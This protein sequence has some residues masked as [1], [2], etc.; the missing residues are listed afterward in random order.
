[1]KKF[2]KAIAALM[3]MTAAIVAVGCKPENE[4]NNGNG[5]NGGGDNGG[6][7]EPPVTVTFTVSGNYNSHNY[8]DLGLPSG[9]LWATCN[10]GADS[11]EGYGYYLAWGETQPKDTTYYWDTY[12][13]SATNDFHGLTK[14]CCNS[15]FGFNGFTDGLK[16][17]LPEDDAATVN[18]GGDWQTPSRSDWEE[19]INNCTNEWITTENANGRLFTAPNGNTLFLPAAGIYGD[20]IGGFESHAHYWM[21]ELT[22]EGVTV[23]QDY[24]FFS[25]QASLIGSYRCQGE[26][27]RPVL[28]K[29][30]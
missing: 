27:V 18:W 22:E 21:N 13:Y 30:N 12:K 9:N 14:Y 20:N 23:A 29:S 17:L 2:T 8:V 24:V 26:S 19:L 1:M 7:N 3:L 6:G 28:H 4:P 15:E 10:V 25:Y 16:V 5:D 11:P